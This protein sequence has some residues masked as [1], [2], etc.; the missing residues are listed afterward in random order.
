MTAQVR[1]GGVSQDVTL[2]GIDAQG[3][4]TKKIMNEEAKVAYQYQSEQQS[5]RMPQRSPER[6]VSVIFDQSDIHVDPDQESDAHGLGEEI[7][8]LMNE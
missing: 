5:F 3:S 2:L 4:D 8:I 1:T 7:G 6:D